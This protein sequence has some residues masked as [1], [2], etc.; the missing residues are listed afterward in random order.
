V[1]EVIVFWRRRGVLD[2]D[3]APMRQVREG[4]W[5]ARFT[6]P[7][8]STRYAVEYYIEARDLGGRAVGRVAGPET[9]LVLPVAP[10]QRDRPAWYRR[11]YVV[12][13]G[14]AV[15]GVGTVILV[16]GDRAPDGT[17]DPDRITL[18]P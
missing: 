17:L 16:S 9:P 7:A 13:G 14:A 11:W 10:G 6:P 15:V 3:R 8:S 1:L 4:R 5:R 2:Y 18:T 12:A